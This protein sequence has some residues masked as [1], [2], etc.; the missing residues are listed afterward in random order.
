MLRRPGQQTLSVPVLAAPGGPLPLPMVRLGGKLQRLRA[1]LAQS[2]HAS[3]SSAGTIVAQ[4]PAAGMP[5]EATSV[6][7]PSLCPGVREDPWKLQ[8]HPAS[9]GNDMTSGPMQNIRPPRQMAWLCLVAPA[10]A[11]NRILRQQCAGVS[12][13]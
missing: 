2:G 11:S 10:A 6:V 3:P 5:A 8:M 13:T 7:G 1:A 12:G 4:A 9:R